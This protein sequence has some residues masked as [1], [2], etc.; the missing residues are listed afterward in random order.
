MKNITTCI[1]L[2][3]LTLAGCSDKS[4]TLFDG[5]T[6]ISKTEKGEFAVPIALRAASA[7]NNA[8]AASLDALLAVARSDLRHYTDSPEVWKFVSIHAYGTEGLEP[9]YQ[10]QFRKDWND[11][12]MIVVAADGTIRGRPASK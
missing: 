3:L 8:E 2:V 5:K 12:I 4:V 6:A 10:I 11:W 7:V 9:A 1:A